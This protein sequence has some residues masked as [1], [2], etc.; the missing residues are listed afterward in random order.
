MFH[1]IVSQEGVTVFTYLDPR[2]LAMLGSAFV[3]LLV[4]ALTKTRASDAIKSIVN[5][6]ATAIVTVLALWINPSETDVTL[7]LVLN[8]F[9]ASFVVSFTAYKGVWK[10]L[11]TSAAVSDLTSGFGVGSESDLDSDRI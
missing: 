9:L 7:P 1:Q 10:P 4:D 8:T 11:G 6:V 2:L 5:V 3:P